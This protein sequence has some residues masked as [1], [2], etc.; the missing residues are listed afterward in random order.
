[1]QVRSQSKYLPDHLIDHYRYKR[2]VADSSDTLTRLFDRAG[3]AGVSSPKKISSLSLGGGAEH[4]VD[5]G[6]HS[7]QRKTIKEKLLKRE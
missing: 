5:K 3:A 6:F 4:A 7:T 2:R 1:M